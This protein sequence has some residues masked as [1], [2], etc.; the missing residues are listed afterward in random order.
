LAIPVNENDEE[1]FAIGFDVSYN[2]KNQIAFDNYGT[3]PASPLVLILTNEGLLVTFFAINFDSKN[4]SICQESKPMRYVPSI[5]QQR[6]TQ[7]TAP[8]LTKPKPNQINFND[9]LKLG[10]HA[11]PQFTLNDS[12]NKPQ[13]SFD[14]NNQLGLPQLLQANSKMPQANQASPFNFNSNQP[15]QMAAFGQNQKPMQQQQQQQLQQQQ[16]NFSQ[17]KIMP[18]QQYQQEQHQRTAVQNQFQQQQQQNHST[19]TK[20]NQGLNCRAMVNEFEKELEEFW[21]FSKVLRGKNLAKPLQLTKDTSIIA[22]KF[23]ELSNKLKVKKKIF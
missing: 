10:G 16:Q 2:C 13:S 6:T 11:Q 20:Q 15:P 18:Q 1:A 5:I 8:D 9:G 17:S 4:K 7:Q 12:L 14:I 3:Q 23:D 19:P 22:Q 21:A